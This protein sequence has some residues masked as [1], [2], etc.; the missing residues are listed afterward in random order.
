MTSCAC[1][2]APCTLA[3]KRH[4]LSSSPDPQVMLERP[5]W[6]RRRRRKRGRVIESKVNP[7]LCPSLFPCSCVSSH[8]HNLRRFITIIHHSV[9][10]VHFSSLKVKVE[11][12]LMI[13]SFFNKSVNYSEMD[14]K[15]L[16][17]QWN[18]KVRAHISFTLLYNYDL[19]SF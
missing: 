10:F 2:L 18:W 14:H 6:W 9:V 1:R 16:T 4:C 7:V 13:W 8:H 15:S 3:R 11:A 5:R 12:E 17:G 19:Y